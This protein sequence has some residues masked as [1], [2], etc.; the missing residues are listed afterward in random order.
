MN[1]KSRHVLAGVAQ[2]IEY[3]PE[4]QRVAGSIPHQGTFLCCEPGAQ[5]G[6]LRGNHTLI[7][8]SLS[9]EERKKENLS[10]DVGQDHGTT[11]EEFLANFS[12]GIEC[13]Q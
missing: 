12:A 3:W 1:Q 8:T 10:Q 11:Q 2:W 7:F 5:Q 9:K 13:L 6:A 4:N